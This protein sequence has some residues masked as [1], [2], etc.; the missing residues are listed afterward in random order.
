M[1]NPCEVIIETDVKTAAEQITKLVAEEAWRIEFKYS[2]YRSSGVIFDINNKGTKGITLDSE[3]A[4]LV[5]F[6]YRCYQLSDGLFDVSSGILRSVWRFGKTD[7]KIVIPTKEQVTQ[8]LAYVGL[9]KV[10]WQRPNLTL[11]TGMELDFG[12]IGKEYSVDKALS[13]VKSKFETAVLINFGGDIACNK[14][15][16]SQPSWNVAIDT[17]DDKP[18]SKLIELTS[19]A[20]ASSGDNKRFIEHQGKRYGHILNPKTGWPVADSPQSVTVCADTCTTAGLVATLA[21]LSGADAETFLKQQGTAF[22]LY[23]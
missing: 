5:D 4:D 16:Q 3:T 6:C 8:C 19:G 2:R 1:A 20:V 9:N 12:G 10:V 23:W 15:P 21:M 17:P 7:G 11:A 22:Y 18:S 14:P 13:L